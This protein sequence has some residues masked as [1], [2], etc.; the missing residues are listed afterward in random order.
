MIRGALGV[1]VAAALWMFVFFTLAMAL[2]AVWPDYGVHG[3][4]WMTAQSYEFTTQQSLLN[5]LFWVL[6]AIFAGW[7]GV[8]IARR[9]EAAWVLAALIGGYLAYMHLYFY[10]NALPQWYN[11]AVAI[12]AA[13][14]V[15]LGGRLARRFVVGR[16]APIA[17]G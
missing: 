1:V 11:L 10:W 12:P 14:A 5:V 6:A 17:V 9:R 16:K 8:T 15:L 4:A 2:A 3:R 7:V 13:P